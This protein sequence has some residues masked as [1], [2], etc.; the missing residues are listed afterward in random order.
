M[1]A[2]GAGGDCLD[3][4]SLIYQFSFLSPSLWEMVRYRLKSL[5]YCLKGLLT[6][7]IKTE[8]IQRK[9]LLS[10]TFPGVSSFKMTSENDTRTHMIT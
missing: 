2:V 1:L 7:F 3:I 6:N 5:K 4:F 10:K 8:C 9:Q